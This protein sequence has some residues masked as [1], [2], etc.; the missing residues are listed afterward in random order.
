ML[1]NIFQL[2][3]EKYKIITHSWCPTHFHKITLE[4]W[5]HFTMDINDETFSIMIKICTDTLKSFIESYKDKYVFEQPSFFW[6]P[7]DKTCGIRIGTMDI[8]D[9]EYRMKQKGQ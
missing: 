9:Y 8:E 4:G 3:E 2:D 6:N 5:K 7:C 1:T